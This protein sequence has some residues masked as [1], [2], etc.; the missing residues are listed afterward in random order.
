MI[1]PKLFLTD[2]KNEGLYDKMIDIMKEDTNI[3]DNIKSQYVYEEYD[4]IMPIDI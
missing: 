2:L 3:N 1:H 4:I